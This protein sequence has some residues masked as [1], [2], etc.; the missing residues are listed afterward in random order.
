MCWKRSDWMYAQEAS[1]Q[2]RIWIE[3][4]LRAQGLLQ[5]AILA[6][7]LQRRSQK[8]NTKP[9]RQDMPALLLMQSLMPEQPL[10]IRKLMLKLWSQRELP[11]RAAPRALVA[12]AATAIAA[13]AAVAA[14]AARLPATRLPEA[15]EHLTQSIET[16]VPCKRAR[17]SAPKFAVD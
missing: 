17:A 16:F 10:P 6:K 7:A 15:H 5:R 8:R 4:L 3:K 1:E 12:V 2:M 9:E 13:A 11:T 14:A